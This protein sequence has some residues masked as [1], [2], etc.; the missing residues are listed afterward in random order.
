MATLSFPLTS[1][2]LCL[3]CT[4]TYLSFKISA[5]AYEYLGTGKTTSIALKNEIFVYYLRPF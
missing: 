1:I 5:K 3:K 4:G 2:K